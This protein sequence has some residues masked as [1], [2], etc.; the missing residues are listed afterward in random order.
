M[1]RETAERGRN[2]DGAVS[3]AGSR[4]ECVRAQA[5]TGAVRAPFVGKKALV[6]VNVLVLI[7]VGGAGRIRTIFRIG[8]V[9]VLRPHA[10]E[11]KG[12]M[13]GTLCGG[14]V[15]E[16]KLRRPGEIEQIEVKTGRRS[17]VG[18]VRCLRCCGCRRA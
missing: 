16:T 13:R 8:A 3:G 11:D 18:R 15:R 14:G 6:G 7:R 12:G 2:C 4:E 9:V 1:R 10:V 17:C 5:G